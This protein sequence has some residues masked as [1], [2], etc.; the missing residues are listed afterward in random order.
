MNCRW[1]SCVAAMFLGVVGDASAMF[2]GGW[3]RDPS[4][5]DAFGALAMFAPQYLG[6]G[7]FCKELFE[8]I[9]FSQPVDQAMLDKFDQEIGNEFLAVA[10]MDG[11]KENLFSMF[12]CY[13]PA[14]NEGLL[15]VYHHP[16]LRF[17]GK[18]VL[19]AAYNDEGNN[20]YQ[21]R[22][23]AVNS[24]ENNDNDN[25]RDDSTEDFT[26]IKQFNYSAKLGKPTALAL[27]H[28]GMVAVACKR[29]NHRELRSTIYFYD[30]A[31]GAVCEREPSQPYNARITAIC[32]HKDDLIISAKLVE[33]NLHYLYRLTSTDQSTITSSYRPCVS[34]FFIELRS[35]DNES[36]FY[37]R[38]SDELFK[39]SQNTSGW[40]AVSLDKEEICYR[41]FG[42]RFK[43]ECQ[44]FEKGSLWQWNIRDT[45]N[46]KRYPAS[47][48]MLALKAHFMAEQWHN[49]LGT[50]FQYSSQELKKFEGTI[51]PSYYPL[52]KKIPCPD[53]KLSTFIEFMTLQ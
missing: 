15:C 43:V 35:N 9:D 36:C 44:Q 11:Y 13:P 53:K 34:G 46:F 3:D 27:S 14:L 20:G 39:F 28:N 48:L 5:G 40:S 37:A 23:Y 4:A 12:P 33:N 6:K 24:G 42:D 26:L 32:F 29:S 38:S 31:S 21:I 50:M 47:L 1:M 16:S 10:F 17:E 41:K 8:R 45:L 18:E 7:E 22:A 25:D 49:K 51:H 30:L 2:R 19:L 52:L